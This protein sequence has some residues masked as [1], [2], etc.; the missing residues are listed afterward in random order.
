MQLKHLKGSIPFFFILG[1][2]FLALIFLLR[3]SS[4]HNLTRLCV[5]GD[6]RSSLLRSQ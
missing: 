4:H 1:A 6:E 5:A 2:S 3:V